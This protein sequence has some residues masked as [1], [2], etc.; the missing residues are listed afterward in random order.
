[1]PSSFLATVTIA[2][3]AYVG[4]LPTLRTLLGPAFL[5]QSISRRAL[6]T[7]EQAPEYILRHIISLATLF[8]RRRERCIL[9]TVLGDYKDTSCDHS[10]SL[11]SEI[12]V[13]DL[14]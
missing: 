7:P 14:V 1:V 10:Y 8:T 5:A 3:L 4:G 2:S 9:Y 6:F 12:T 11:R 13:G